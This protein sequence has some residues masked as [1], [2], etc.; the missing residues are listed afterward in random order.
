MGSTVV[1]HSLGNFI[2][3]MDF[4]VKT[5]EG[6][7]V[8]IVLWDGQVKAVEPVPYVIDD[9]FTPQTGPRRSRRG[10]SSTTSGPTAGGRTPDPER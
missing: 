5:R 7:F 3:D 1:V 9:G 8:E 4:Q 6:I 10:R 2:F